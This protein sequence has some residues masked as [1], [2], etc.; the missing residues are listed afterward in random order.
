MTLIVSLSQYRIYGTYSTFLLR[1]KTSKGHLLL[2]KTTIFE[3]SF[4]T[5]QKAISFTLK[6][7]GK[8]SD[9]NLQKLRP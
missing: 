6:N 2:L 1:R 7:S 9:R 3:S 4:K 8:F 5:Q